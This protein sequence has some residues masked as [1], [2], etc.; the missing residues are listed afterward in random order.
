MKNV[1]HIASIAEPESLGAFLVFPPCLPTAA[2]A[3]S[4]CRPFTHLY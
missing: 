1:H 2:N 4:T 3:Q